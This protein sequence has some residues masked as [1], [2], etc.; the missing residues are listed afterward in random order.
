MAVLQ[1]RFKQLRVAAADEL[2]ARDADRD[3]LLAA[4]HGLLD[5]RDAELARLRAELAAS[6]AELADS[7]ARVARRNAQ[8]AALAQGGL[9]ARGHGLVA[10]LVCAAGTLTRQKALYRAAFAC[11]Q[12]ELN[13]RAGA[14]PGQEEPAET[15]QRLAR[16]QAAAA[17][18]VADIQRVRTHLKQTLRVPA[19]KRS[20]WNL[21]VP[22]H[23]LKCRSRD[24]HR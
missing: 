13:Y 3:C 20:M 21:L 15:S 14:V 6:N 17:A 19:H 5:M 9:S 22:L 12:L 2:R 11:A 16:L 4:I 10:E 8:L 24:R 18:A 1:E 23:F 7:R